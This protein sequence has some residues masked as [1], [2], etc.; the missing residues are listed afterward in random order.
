MPKAS[1]VYSNVVNYE[2]TT[3]S[4]SNNSILNLFYKSEIPMGL[5]T[6]IK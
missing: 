2:S 3:P 4:G 1:K 6:T 5:K